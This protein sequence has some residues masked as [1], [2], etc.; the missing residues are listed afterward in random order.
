MNGWM[1]PPVSP[2]RKLL[3]TEHPISEECDSVNTENAS[4][5]ISIAG[6]DITLELLVES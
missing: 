5:C 1:E 4:G 2:Q 3:G 6:L